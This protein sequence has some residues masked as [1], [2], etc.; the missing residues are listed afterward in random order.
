[1]RGLRMPVAMLTVFVGR[2]GVLL[3]LVVLA[4]RVVMGRLEV[5]VGGSLVMGGSL[6]VMLDGRV[7]LLTSHDASP[8][9]LWSGAVTFAP[10]V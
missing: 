5:V 3:G 1:V 6:V 2:R 7:L 4:E 8:T 9:W 10:R